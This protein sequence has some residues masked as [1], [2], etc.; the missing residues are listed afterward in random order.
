MRNFLLQIFAY[1]YI[2][3][4]V[5]IILEE[6][7]KLRDCPLGL[8]LTIIAGIYFVSVQNYKILK[9]LFKFED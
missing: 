6:L 7:C 1:A 5:A 8:I 2:A 4:Y 9:W 3:F